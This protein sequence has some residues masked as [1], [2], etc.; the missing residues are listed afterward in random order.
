M[1]LDIFSYKEFIKNACL[2][3]KIGVDIPSQYL[4]EPFENILKVI[5]RY[6]IR[7]GRF[8]R[9]YP[10]HIRLLMHFTGKNPLNL[11][12]ILYRILGKMVDNV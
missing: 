5:I 4:L 3:R 1:P 2:N 10:Y 7:E 11:P 9:V 8:D 12:F 6:F